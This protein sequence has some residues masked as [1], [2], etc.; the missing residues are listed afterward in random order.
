MILMSS[1]QVRDKAAEFAS[2]A[3]TMAGEAERQRYVNMARYW[4]LLASEEIG[5]SVTGVEATLVPSHLSA[6]LEI[7]AK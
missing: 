7:S 5:A 1:D 2:T 6:P 4:L 3:A